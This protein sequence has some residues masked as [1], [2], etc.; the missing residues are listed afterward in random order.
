VCTTRNAPHQTRQLDG[1][2]GRPREP[3]IAC[4]GAAVAQVPRQNLL[5]QHVRRLDANAD[6]PHQNEDHQIRSSLGGVLHLLEAGLLDLADRLG[7]ELLSR[8]IA[9]QLRKRVIGKSL[10]VVA[11]DAVS[12][13][14]SM[15]E[16]LLLMRLA[17][18]QHTYLAET[19]RTTPTSSPG[20][21]RDR[22]GAQ[23]AAASA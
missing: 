17:L 20:A 13:I 15:R 7:N 21:L 2:H 10:E 1:T 23:A 16:A 8:Q 9:L 3:S 22:T 14:A 19:S 6:H 12:Y 11:A 5:D 4:H 18:P